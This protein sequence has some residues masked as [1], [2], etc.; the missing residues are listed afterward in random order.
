MF[1]ALVW[2]FRLGNAHPLKKRIMNNLL[3]IPEDVFEVL[4]KEHMSEICGG[5]TDTGD[6]GDV[7]NDGRKCFADNNNGECGAT[8]LGRTC[9]AINDKSESCFAK[10]VKR[11]CFIDAV[12]GPPVVV[13][14]SYGSD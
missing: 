10:N 2:I 14:G 7:T 9:I 1:V 3:T 4:S 8:N 11:K 12:V 13:G 5:V 6:N